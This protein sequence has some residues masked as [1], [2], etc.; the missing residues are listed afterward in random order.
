MDPPEGTARRNTG[1]PPL[2]LHTSRLDH[3]VIG[4]VRQQKKYFLVTLNKSEFDLPR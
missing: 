3:S 4:G 2:L 1:T